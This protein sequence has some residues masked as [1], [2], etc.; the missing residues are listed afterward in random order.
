MD[1]EEKRRKRVKRYARRDKS[2]ERVEQKN[3][4][5]YPRVRR[6]VSGPK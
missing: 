3:E 6:R 1:P 5:I 2:R 4:K